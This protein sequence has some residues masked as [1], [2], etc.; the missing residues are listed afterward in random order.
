[1]ESMT[2]PGM[3][4]R[5]GPPRSPRP[6]GAWGARMSCGTEA[7]GR[8]HPRGVLYGQV[9]GLGL[10]VEGLVEREPGAHVPGSA[11]G[12]SEPGHSGRRQELWGHCLTRTLGGDVAVW[13]QHC[14]HPQTILGES[15]ARAPLKCWHLPGDIS[16]QHLHGRPPWV[17][18]G[19]THPPQ[20]RAQRQGVCCRHLQ[21]GASGGVLEEGGRQ[22]SPLV[23]ALWEEAQASGGVTGQGTFSGDGTRGRRAGVLRQCCGKEATS[24][25]RTQRGARPQRCPW[26]WL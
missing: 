3:A 13:G 22:A 6:P 4:E 15:A 26:G 8:Y 7:D 10:P 18:L 17:A 2:S 25:A 14:R 11:E 16:G 19:T 23:M 21:G 20:H 1:M 24:R 12:A 9:P 5:S